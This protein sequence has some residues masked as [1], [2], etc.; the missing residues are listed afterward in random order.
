MPSRGAAEESSRR[1]PRLAPGCDPTRLALSPAEGFLLSRIDGHTPQGVLRM[2]GGL[3]P[4]DVDRCLADWARDGIVLFGG[5]GPPARR[6]APGRARAPRGQGA[7]P[8]AETCAIDAALEIDPE[9]QRAILAMEARLERP[10]HEI[11][12]VAPDAD[13]RTVKRAYF[14]LSKEFH[15]DRYFRREIGP[16]RERLEAV[17]RKVVE[18]YELLSDPA[19]RAEVE[20]SLH[21]EAAPA[22]PPPARPAARRRRRPDAFSPLLRSLARRK[23]KAKTLFEAGMA[24]AAE[25]RWIEAAGSVRLAIAFDPRNPLYRERFGEIQPRAHEVRFEQLIKEADSA[26]SFRDRLDALRIYEEALHFRPYDAAANFTAA[27]LAW[28]A[29]EDLRR[30]K[31]YA[32]RACE[33]DP[34]NAEYRKVLGLIYKAA[35]LHANARRELQKAVRLDPADDEAR[36][37][38]KSL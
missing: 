11:L 23:A 30:A 32:A 3:P 26:L 12:G 36:A 9:A 34:E 31:E 2:V 24:A 14:A 13:T 33:A 29:A 19:V 7:R 27:R 20:R 28:L 16:F 4:A 25:Q 17:F 5:S 8:Q 35:G 38:L 18:A 15:P 37:E 6:H 1:I 21:A 22:T 10:Y